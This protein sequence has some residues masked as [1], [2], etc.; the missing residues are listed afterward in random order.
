MEVTNFVPV[1]HGMEKLYEPVRVLSLQAEV[2]MLIVTG[3]S[4]NAA[5]LT[6]NGGANL[7]AAVPDQLTVTSPHWVASLKLACQA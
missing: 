3:A 4:P 5:I 6:T 7:S 1:G 2:G